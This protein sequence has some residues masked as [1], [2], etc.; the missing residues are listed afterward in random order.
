MKKTETC[1]SYGISRGILIFLKSVILPILGCG[2]W[3][4]EQFLP[5]GFELLCATLP[6]A[7]IITFAIVFYKKYRDTALVILLVAVWVALFYIIYCFWNV[8]CGITQETTLMIMGVTL[9]VIYIIPS[10][11]TSFAIFLY[12]RCHK[13]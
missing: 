13:K 3:I 10:L 7:T 1:N 5:S 12:S 2:L 11:L 4:S 8:Y 6:T 9:A